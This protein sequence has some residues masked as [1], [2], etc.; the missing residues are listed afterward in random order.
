MTT[1]SICSK[2][3]IM[4]YYRVLPA[5]KLPQPYLTYCFIDKLEIGQ[6]VE[7]SIRGGVVWA[8]VVEIYSEDKDNFGFDKEKIKPIT[9]PL[10]YK[11]SKSQINFLY[12]F[13]QNT[14]NSLNLSL[15]S[16]LQPFKL[17]T[18]KQWKEL[19]NTNIN[20]SK[21]PETTP[22]EEKIEFILDNN[23][24]LR[25]IYIIR[26]YLNKQTTKPILITFPEKKY[27]EKIHQ[28]IATNPEFKEIREQVDL[29][30]FTGEVNQKN[31]ITLWEILQKDNSK[32]KIIFST[33]VGIFLPFQELTSIIL[34]DEANSLYIQDQNS[35]Y[36]DA[37]DTVFLL[38]KALK[39]NLTFLSSLPSVRL[40]NF[41]SETVLEQFMTK[42]LEIDI[43]RLNI[44][45]S[46]GILQPE[47]I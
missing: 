29:L 37:R 25:I 3:I 6:V 40:Y 46:N 11:F 45:I 19:E 35:L 26:S 23:I 22:L 27:L 20:Q 28:E 34:V 12:S 13:S 15:G 36:F 41:Y 14:F 8:L 21:R 9:K 44:Q 43:K 24:S 16:L 33:R 39:T 38:S 32:L 7:V 10:P 4:Y 42:S 18:Q 47:E 30:F 2:V 31:K 1:Q 17:L 5:R